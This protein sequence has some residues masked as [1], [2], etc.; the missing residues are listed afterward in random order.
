MRRITQITKTAVDP[1]F[2]AINAHRQSTATRYPIL[3]LMGKTRDAA[4]ERRAM[5]AAHDEA[6]D[7]EV[8]A[9]VRLR[10]TLPT[11]A[12]GVEAV[13]A[14]CVE[15]MDR[16]PGWIGG[17]IPSK[18]GS[19]YYPEHRTFEDSMIRTLAAALAIIN[20]A[21]TVKRAA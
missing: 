21:A 17:A 11:T 12:A 14:Y 16:Y 4:P 7:I 19:H 6:A 15:H 18:P 20:G 5:E 8:A 13:L 1:I 2:A 10:K 9:T 3:D